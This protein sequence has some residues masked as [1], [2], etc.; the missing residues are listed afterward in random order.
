[1]FQV[2]PGPSTNTVPDDPKLD[3]IVAPPPL[4]FPP[5]V[6]ASVPPPARPT[7]TPPDVPQK[8]PAPSTITV[9]L[10]PGWYAI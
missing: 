5:L 1:M 2:D 10:E 6:I 8:D 9:P 3:P 7:L 4:T